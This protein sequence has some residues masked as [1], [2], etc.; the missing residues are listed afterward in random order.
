MICPDNTP[1][2]I[3][4]PRVDYTQPTD[5]AY[6]CASDVLNY[7]DQT[8]WRQCETSANKPA[9]LGTVTYNEVVVNVNP[10]Y[11]PVYSK[12]NPVTSSSGPLSSN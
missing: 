9:S 7:T 10:T 12:V 6:V 3:G 4:T 1:C 8:K 2:T 11:P 5:K